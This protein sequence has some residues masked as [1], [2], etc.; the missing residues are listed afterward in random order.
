MSHLFL[1]VERVYSGQG[2]LAELE[3]A[4]PR[5][6]KKALLV[7][8]KSAMRKAGFTEKVLELLKKGK[9]EAVLFEEVEPNPSLDA[10]D[11][12]RALLGESGSDFV[13]GLGGGSALDAAKVIAGLAGEAEPTVEFFYKRAER[14]NPAVP[15]VAIPTT[16]GTGAEAT[17][18]GVISDAGTDRKR[19]IRYPDFMAKVAILDPALTVTMP[20][21]ITA[22][23]GMD[24]LTQAIESFVSNKAHPLTE[25][26]SKEAIR[27]I[28]RGLKRAYDDGGDLAARGEM[29]YGSFLAGVA[30]NNAGLGV[31]HGMAHPFTSVYGIPHGLACAV[32]LPVALEFNRAAIGRKYDFISHI[33]GKD[34]IEFINGMLDYLKLNEEYAKNKIDE[35][36]FDIFIEEGMS[37]GSTKANPREVSK[38]NIIDILK[39]LL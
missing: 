14:K 13:I 35:E 8:G 38:Q 23:A 3:K 18:N 6:G 30:L 29:H 9:V 2:A 12:G 36:H 34:T 11:R 21:F 28:S 39:K 19:S 7:T 33:I 16:S 26:C 1:N 4:A 17:K 31:V 10:C 25:A 37:S 27:L 22:I 15:F 32:L 24:A 5:I 20:P